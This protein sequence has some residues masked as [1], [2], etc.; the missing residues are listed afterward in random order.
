MHDEITCFW[1]QLTLEAVRHTPA[2]LEDALLQAGAMVVTLQDAGEQPILEPLPGEA[3]LWSRTRVTGLFEAQTDIEVVKQA[4]CQCL[5]SDCLPE[6]RMEKLEERDWVRA[7]MD[8][9]HPMCF[10]RRL[11][12]C[13]TGRSAPDPKAVQLTLDPGLAFGTGTHPTTAL[14]LEWLDEA[15]MANKTVIDYGCGSGILAI[16]AVKLGARR[17]WA[18]DI[19]PQA[20]LA[21]RQNA[22]TN[23]VIEKVFPAPPEALSISPVDI[24]LA[25]ILA[26]PLIG[27]APR[28]AELVETRGRIVLAGLLAQQ[29]QE[30]GD[31]FSP[32]FDIQRLKQREEWVLLEAVRTDR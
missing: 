20:L 17:T 15:E 26:G 1:F 18:V 27:L 8:N 3:P 2:Q 21:T 13:P 12:V 25:N 28:F 23:E 7:W 4:L 22:I 11:W 31:A 24:I 5:A 9:F 10:G 19:D 14:C 30:V 32:W 6:C 29:T 16:A